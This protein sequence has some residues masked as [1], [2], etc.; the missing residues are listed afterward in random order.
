MSGCLALVSTEPKMAEAARIRTTARFHRGLAY[1]VAHGEGTRGHREHEEHER[2]PP[3]QFE[4][5]VFRI[6]FLGRSGT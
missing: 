3:K 6:I 1:I 2:L 5:R 4:F